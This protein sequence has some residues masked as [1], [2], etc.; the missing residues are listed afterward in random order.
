MMALQKG[1]HVLCEKPLA[2]NGKQVKKLIE[3]AQEKKLFFMEAIW[4]RFFEAYK[5]L[6]ERIDDGSLGDIKNVD[7]EF[8]FPLQDTP[9]MF[10]KNGGGESERRLV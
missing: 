4:S 10:L 5:L 6:K 1:K 2:L 7:L 9:R 3:T 8:G